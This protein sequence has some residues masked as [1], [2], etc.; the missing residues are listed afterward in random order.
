MSR[1]VLVLNLDPDLDVEG[2]RMAGRLE[3][4]EGVR[5]VE[6][7][8]L[9][10]SE[11]F[12]VARSTVIAALEES[13]RRIIADVGDGL[14]TNRLIQHLSA[15]ANAPDDPAPGPEP[16]DEERAESMRVHDAELAQVWEAHRERRA[17]ERASAQAASLTADQARARAALE[18]SDRRAE[19]ERQRRAREKTTVSDYGPT[20]R[21]TGSERCRGSCS[22]G[23]DGPSCGKPGCE[24]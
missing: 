20:P 22:R 19:A 1:L 23:G 13:T 3:S 21:Y 11:D 10:D 4:L 12:L 6:V 24:G 14:G 17:H 18:E 7:R 8:R 9:E 16:T 15:I 2:Y 5:S